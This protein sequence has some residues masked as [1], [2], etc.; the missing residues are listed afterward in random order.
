MRYFVQPLLWAAVFAVTIA[1]PVRGQGAVGSGPLTGAL[2]DT[3]PTAGVLTI[4]R[5]RV[6]PGVVV[7]EVGWDTNVFDEAE[8]PKEDFIVSVAPD[9]AFFTRLRFLQLSAYAGA[10]FN[11]FR[12]FDQENS[13]GHTLKGRADILLSRVRPFAAGGRTRSRTRPNGEIDVRADRLEEEFS[14]GLAFDISRYGQLY[15]AAY[16]FRTRFRDA[17][18]DGV[19]LAVTLNRDSNQYSGGLRTEITPLLSMIA[20]VA[21]REELFRADPLRNAQAWFATADFRFDPAAVIAGQIAV[22]FEEFKPANPAVRPF[23][24]VVGNATIFYSLLEVGR[25]GVTA[26]RRTEFSFNA[27]DAYF[28]EN[29]V[30]L[31]YTHRLFGAA[32]AQLKGA[33]SFFDYGF[34]DSSPARRE[35]LDLIGASVGYNL[36]NRTRISINYEFVNRRSPEFVERNYDRRR[37]FVAWTF[38]Y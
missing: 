21:F 26:V 31:S 22:S 34:S 17:F 20:S 37:T 8:N 12:T 10:D 38:A 18:E 5:V 16:Q 28:V 23:R 36:R 3:E 27:E 15:G 32:D 19:N 13:V 2:T 14:G 33:K 29:G 25:I 7:R 30:T 11:Y 4:G 6:A 35:T 1:A 9:A 24:G